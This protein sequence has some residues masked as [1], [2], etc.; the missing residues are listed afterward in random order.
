MLASLLPGEPEAAAGALQNL[1]NDAEG[2]VVIAKAGGLEGLIQLLENGS[3]SGQETAA[4]ALGNL[5]LN[6]DNR[7]AIVKQGGIPLLVS[8]RAIFCCRGLNK[9][10]N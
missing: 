10:T 8:S 6:A 7:A 3:P 5:S 4:G 9:S 2:R 1:A